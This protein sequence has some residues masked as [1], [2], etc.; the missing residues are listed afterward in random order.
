MMLLLQVQRAGAVERGGDDSACFAVDTTG[1]LVPL[2]AVACR[3]LPVITAG[4]CVARVTSR[5]T[6]VIARIMVPKIRAARP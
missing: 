1:T 3:R 6:R 5:A 4:N 2:L